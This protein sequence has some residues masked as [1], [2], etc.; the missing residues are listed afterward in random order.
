MPANRLE[1]P[2]NAD[3]KCS[4]RGQIST[5]GRKRAA[6]LLEIP[7]K[8]MLPASSKVARFDPTA[9]EA[10]SEQVCYDNI[11]SAATEPTNNDSRD[12]HKISLTE[13]KEAAADKVATP[14]P[15]QHHT[16]STQPDGK[17]SRSNGISNIGSPGTAQI[18]KLIDGNA[19]IMR[20]TTS[21]HV[22]GAKPLLAAAKSPANLFVSKVA[23]SPQ[24]Y[25]T[26]KASSLEYVSLPKG[27]R[28][29][30]KPQI[31]QTIVPEN[32]AS[33]QLLSTA[34]NHIISIPASTTVSTTAVLRGSNYLKSGDKQRI[35]HT[36]SPSFIDTR[37]VH[38]KYPPQYVSKA[39]TAI[40]L[41][42]KTV[43]IHPGTTFSRGNWK[44][45]RSHAYAL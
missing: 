34:T 2:T 39:G 15:V 6:V 7:A 42:P 29:A 16:P 27:V 19:I 14:K 35:V 25:V 24:S 44:L 40:H 12:Q 36:V 3:D 13:C 45:H 18:L 23:S 43:T 32:S 28:A 33:A 21:A 10:E 11:E 41:K 37:T 8:S 22:V 4:A 20:P 17:V 38:D 1:S 26:L 5:L 30:A 31:I 9:V